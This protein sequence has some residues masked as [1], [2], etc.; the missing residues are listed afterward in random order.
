MA[1]FASVGTSVWSLWQ[2]VRYGIRLLARHPGFFFVGVLTLALG[3][4]ANTTIFAW[5]QATLLTPIP[6]V[7]DARDFVA[8]AKRGPSQVSPPP[9]SYLDYRDL[10]SGARSFPGL[11]A[12]HDDG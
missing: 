8:F 10:R 3:V 9:S 7:A 1:M 6:G 11:L 5:I 2:D 4:G 12:Y